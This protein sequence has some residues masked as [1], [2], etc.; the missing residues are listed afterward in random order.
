VTHHH[1]RRVHRG[2]HVSLLAAV[3][4]AA[5]Q[6]V[7]A[8]GF[9]QRTTQPRPIEAALNLLY[10]P[11]E[12]IPTIVVVDQRPPTVNPLAEGWVVRNSDGSAQPTIYIA[13]WS[14]PYRDALANPLASRSHSIIRLAGVLAHERAHLRHGADEEIAYAAQLTTLVIL[15]APDVEISNVRR[16]LEL[17]KRRQRV[18]P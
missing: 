12:E 17:V 4:F 11:P 13:G 6:P 9:A 14:E 18:R 1:T 10:W 15:Q 7:A 8:V 3:A 16:A 5:V 2:I